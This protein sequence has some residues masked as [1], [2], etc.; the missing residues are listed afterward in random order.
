VSKIRKVKEKKTLAFFLD[1]SF[2]RRPSLFLQP[3]RVTP[4][5]RHRPSLLLQPRRVAAQP[6]LDALSLKPLL[7]PSLY[8]RAALSPADVASGTAGSA[9]NMLDDFYFQFFIASLL[10]ICGYKL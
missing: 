3:R 7:S 6:A 10:W 4:P 5:P 9:G 2:S 1:F 8:Q